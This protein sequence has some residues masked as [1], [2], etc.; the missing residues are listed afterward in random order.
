MFVRDNDASGDVAGQLVRAFGDRFGSN[1]KVHP[2]EVDRIVR[3]GRG[4]FMTILD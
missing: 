1:L 3:T 2:R 4:K